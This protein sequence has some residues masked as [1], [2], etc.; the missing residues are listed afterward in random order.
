M[1]VNLNYR[2]KLSN[3]LFTISSKN[4]KSINN[5]LFFFFKHIK[6]HKNL[7]KFFPIKKTTQ[8][9]TIL[10]SPHVNKT[11][12]EQFESKKFSEK[13]LL[14]SENMTFSII[15]IKNLLNKIFH[16]LKITIKINQKFPTPYF[17]KILNFYNFKLIQRDKKYFNQILKKK[18]NETKKSFLKK[19]I[20]K[21]ANLNVTL[22]MSSLKGEILTI[23]TNNFLKFE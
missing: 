8:K 6:T 9:I 13:I 2:I 1:V 22:K 17:S 7:S 16:D 11:A 12:Q 23:K 4:K 10:K 19:K 15:I 18:K 21:I 5:F 20:N 3:F 14:N